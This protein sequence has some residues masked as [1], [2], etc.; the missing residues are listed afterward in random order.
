MKIYKGGPDG[1][2]MAALS[3]CLQQDFTAWKIDHIEEMRDLLWENKKDFITIERYPDCFPEDQGKVRFDF[4]LRDHKAILL[5]QEPVPHAI[6]Y[7]GG[8]V[9]DSKDLSSQHG[10]PSNVSHALIIIESS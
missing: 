4:V 9:Y 7:I 6:A 5:I 8:V 3:T 1:C 2:L 10:I